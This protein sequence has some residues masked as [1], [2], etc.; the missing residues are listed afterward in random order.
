MI[1][2]FILAQAC[3]DIYAEEGTWEHVWD[4]N[5]AHAG[6]RKIGEVDVIA[7]RGSKDAQDWLH[8]FEIFPM[9][10]D[11]LGFVHSGFMCGMN[12]ALAEILK[13]VGKRVVVTGHSLGG[14]RAR[15]MAGL[16][17]Y[18]QRPVEQCV[19]FGSPRPGFANLT[20]VLQKSATPLVSYRNRNDPIPLVPYVGGLYTHPDPWVALDAAPPPDDLEP[21]RDHHVAL[22]L[23]ALEKEAA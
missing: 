13:V 9:W 7:F 8:D 3:S 21:L 17:A 15:I 20:R 16:L 11:R 5:G 12:E 19:V 1:S 18:L 2:P 14:A 22:Y 4:F 23:A 6:H 10:D